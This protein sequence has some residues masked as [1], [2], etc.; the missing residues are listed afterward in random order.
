[1]INSAILNLLKTAVES[2]KI[3]LIAPV[4]LARVLCLFV[5]FL[6]SDEV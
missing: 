4:V 5:T 6:S 2:R 1:M 3:T